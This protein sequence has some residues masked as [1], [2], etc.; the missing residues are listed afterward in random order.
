MYNSGTE[1][2]TLFASGTWDFNDH[3]HFQSNI[4]YNDRSTYVEDAGY[5]FQPAFTLPG[6]STLIGLSP[7]S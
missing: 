7:D 1:R 4:L 3:V 6:S 5:P 2:K